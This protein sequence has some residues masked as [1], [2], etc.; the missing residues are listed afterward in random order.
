[1]TPEQ[2][3]LINQIYAATASGDAGTLQGLLNQVEQ[4]AG[5]GTVTG[6]LSGLAAPPQNQ[7]DPII[8]S[9]ESF[10]YPNSGECWYT[11]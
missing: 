11:P 5:T 8:L 1:M 4:T 3:N 10:P 6:G 9:S 2:Q 7:H